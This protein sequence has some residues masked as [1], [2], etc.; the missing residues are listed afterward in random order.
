MKPIQSFKSSTKDTKKSKSR[1]IDRKKKKPEQKRGIAFGVVNQFGLGS[2]QKGAKPANMSVKLAEE[3]ITWICS[4][5][6]QKGRK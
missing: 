4:A 3:L 1:K 5:G 6:R 2:T